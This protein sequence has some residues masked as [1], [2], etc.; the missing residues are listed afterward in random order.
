M[1]AQDTPNASTAA[2][3]RLRAWLDGSFRYKAY[4]GPAPAG[5]PQMR[6][7]VDAI[8]SAM[9]VAR[10]PNASTLNA[11]QVAAMVARLRRLKWVDMDDIAD[12]LEALQRQ[13]DEAQAKVQ[14]AL[15]GVE[16]ATP[17][18]T[19]AS[20]VDALVAVATALS[21]RDAP[22]A[23][24]VG[25]AAVDVLAE[26]QRQVEAE[27][28]APHKDDDYQ[29]N[30][31]SRAAVAYAHPS[32]KMS[33]GWMTEGH[34]GGQHQFPREVPVD[35][36]FHPHWWKPTTRRRNLVKA[37]ALILA[38]IERLDRQNPALTRP[39]ITEAKPD[40]LVEALEASW[41]SFCDA[42]PDDLTSPEDF[43]NHAL[44]TCEQ[45]VQ[46]ALAALDNDKESK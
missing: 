11:A 8:L 38:E 9:P 22:Q 34:D 26:R 36:P 46:F 27:G 13:L 18:A 1:S 28:W 2:A 29:R 30:E 20:E 24:P 42:N 37:G 41:T 31:L 45:F 43:P 44:M 35:W 33:S 39:Q 14:I 4:R 25:F 32:P 5:V 15:Y 12:A 16:H 21:K 17:S 7:D 23:Q 10:T 19:F 3:E 6:S 40:A